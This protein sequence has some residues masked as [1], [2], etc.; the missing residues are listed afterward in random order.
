[1]SVDGAESVA[2]VTR[3]N[4]QVRVEIGP[5]DARM[6]GVAASGGQLALDSSGRLR[7]MPD[8]SVAASVTGF[9]AG[10][11]VEVRFYPEPVLLGR[12]RVGASGLLEGMYAVPHA[13]EN[14]DHQI[15]LIGVARGSRVAFSLSVAVGKETG[16][17]NPLIV[18]LPVAVAAVAALLLPV[19]WRRRRHDERAVGGR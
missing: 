7:V 9:D 13:T 5:V 3:E 6:W 2:Q 4:N 1:M 15:V 12:T 10:S 19:A 14:G 11:T 16:G 17:F 18:I 8:D